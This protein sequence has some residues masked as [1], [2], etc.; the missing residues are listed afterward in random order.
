MTLQN[1]K[2]KTC[3]YCGIAGMAL[4]DEVLQNVESEGVAERARKVHRFHP[5]TNGAAGDIERDL[6]LRHN[7]TTV[8]RPD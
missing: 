8:I 2:T 4:S 7:E 3:I 5:V 6:A 1:A